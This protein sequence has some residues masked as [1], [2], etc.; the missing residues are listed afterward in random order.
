M[1]TN[2]MTIKVQQLRELRR[3]ADELDEEMEAIKDEIKAHMTAADITE[4]VGVDYKISWKPVES[5]RFDKTAMIRTFGQDCYDRFCKVT[6][7]RRFTLA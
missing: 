4:L 1:S 2:E 5:K 7:S 6:T 3:M